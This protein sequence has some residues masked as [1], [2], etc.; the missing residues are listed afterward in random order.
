MGQTIRA[1]VTGPVVST[2]AGAGA[3]RRSSA[4]SPQPPRAWQRADEPLAAGMCRDSGGRPLGPR[5]TRTRRDEALGRSR[6]R[7]GDGRAAGRSNASMSGR[8]CGG[9]GGGRRGPGGSAGRSG[10][11]GG[12]G[13]RAGSGRA[14]SGRAG[15]VPDLSRLLGRHGG[16][17]PDYRIFSVFA[18]R[19]SG[20]AAGQR[21]LRLPPGATRGLPR[22]AAPRWPWPPAGLEPTGDLAVSPR[23]RPG[24]AA[25]PWPAAGWSLGAGVRGRPGVEAPPDT[26][27]A[28][29]QRGGPKGPPASA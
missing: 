13:K 8:W 27:R 20:P 17:D 16:A 29:P 4:P 26:H 21:G 24:I 22:R 7:A 25:P 23:P 18:E 11:N 12:R 28:P 3:G 15:P 1:P 19:D 14:T 5:A 10:P 9:P 6:R 2:P